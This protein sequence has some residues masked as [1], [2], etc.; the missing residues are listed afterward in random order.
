[1]EIKFLVATDIGAKVVRKFY[2]K[3]PQSFLQQAVLVSHSKLLPILGRE[4]ATDTL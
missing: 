2:S 4:L 1:M 3:R